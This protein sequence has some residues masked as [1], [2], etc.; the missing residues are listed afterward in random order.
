MKVSW[1][2]EARR[3]HREIREYIATDNRRAAREWAIETLTATK[4]LSDLPYIGRVVP[5]FK[6]EELREII[7][8]R[9]YRIVYRVREDEIEIVTIAHTAQ[10]LEAIMSPEST[11]EKS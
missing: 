3:K 9:H 6:R 1:S 8:S 2:S 11:E 10:R 7:Y 4:K 5:E